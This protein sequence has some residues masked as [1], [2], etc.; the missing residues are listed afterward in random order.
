M[1]DEK[2]SDALRPDD[3]ADQAQES[4][5]PKTPY[6]APISDAAVGADDGQGDA[7]EAGASP[8]EPGGARFK[9][10]WARAKTAEAEAQQLRE[11]KARLEGQLEATRTAA[12]VTESKPEPRLTWAQLEA[13][14]EEG[15]I[16]RAQAMDY[17]E[18]SIRK[19]LEVK[20]DNRLKNVLATHSRGATVQSEIEQYKSTVP[21]IKTKGTPERIKLEQ[22]FSYLVSLGYD[23][24]DSRTELL[25]CRT[26]FGDVKVAQERQ[27]AKTTI[28][29]RDTMQD[30]PASGKP[31]P[32]AK[33]PLKTIT[34]EQRKYYQRMIDKGQYKGWAEVRE[35]LAFVPQR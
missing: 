22:E 7:G 33:D 20:F 6:A 28:Q 15:K 31:K 11:A 21:E 4:P 13:G 17:R 34:G 25:A 30:I 19:E 35:E 5:E 18:E 1:A 9:Q 2:E 29:E 14:I 27:A 26:T 10:V 23:E 3:S 16:T 24:N 8:L 12:P 32:D